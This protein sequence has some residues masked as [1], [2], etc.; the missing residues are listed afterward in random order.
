MAM[1]DTIFCSYCGIYHRK[2]E[3]RLVSVKAGKRWRCLKSLASS[4]QGKIE[5]E[6]FGKRVTE[7]NAAEQSHRV[8]QRLQAKHR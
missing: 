3:M 2:D 6:A 4:K 5:R 8:R 7:M 1:V